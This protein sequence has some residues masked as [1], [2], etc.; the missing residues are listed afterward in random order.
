MEKSRRAVVVRALTALTI[1]VA[2][3][4]TAGSA[5]SAAITPAAGIQIKIAHSNKCLN[6]YNNSMANDAAIIQYTCSAAFVNDKFRVR[7]MAGG[8]YQIIANSSSKCLN[9]YKGAVVDNTVVNQY[10]C[11]DTAANNLWSFVPVVGKPTFRIVSKQSGKCLNVSKGVVDNSAPLI[12]YTCTAATTPTN[13]QFYFPP[14]ASPTPTP[15]AVSRS[16][17]MAAV[18]GKPTGAVVGPLVY[19][20]L[21]NGGRLMRAYQPDPS[22]FGNLTYSP[23]AGLEQ[24]AGHPAMNVQADGKVFTAVRNTEDGDLWQIT[25]NANNADNF[26]TPKDVGGTGAQQPAIGK[27]PDGKLVTFAVVNGSMWHLPQD[28]TNLPYAAWRQIGGSNLTGEPTVVT[29]RDGLRLFSLT[30]T[31]SL[32]TAAYRNGLLSDWVSLGTQTFTGTVAAAVFPGY[33]TRVVVRDA[34]G[35]IFTK[36]EIATDTFETAWTQVGDF[37]A[38]GSPATVMDQ[39]TGTAAIVARGADDQIHVTF[40]TAQASGTFADWRV[41]VER[42]VTTDP[43]ILSYNQPSGDSTVPAWGWAVRDVNDQP[44]FVHA[45]LAGSNALRTTKGAAKVAD[46]PSFTENILPAPPK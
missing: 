24:F 43:A 30:T 12:I 45:N 6:V 4:L 32:V 31:G 39:K 16:T 35:L 38:V 9:V 37:T 41:P 25:Q 42:A 1:V 40:E 11:S 26:G 17:P 19:T 7:P 5:A 21:D 15:L 2:G 13:D 33:R 18:Q 46:R 34:Q 29:I 36:S 8:T 22:N 20:Y 3:S 28:G 14:A 10:T 44:F 23:A 27:L